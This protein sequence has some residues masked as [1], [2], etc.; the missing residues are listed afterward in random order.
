MASNT[1]IPLSEADRHPLDDEMREM[2]EFVRQM[3]EERRRNAK[4]PRSEDPLF[5]NVPVFKGP[6]PADLSER[7]DDYLFGDAD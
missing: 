4:L 5:K 3:E 1:A 7:H 6:V 2:Q